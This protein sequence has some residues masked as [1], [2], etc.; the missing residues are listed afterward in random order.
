MQ[1]SYLIYRLLSAHQSVTH[2]DEIIEAERR[3]ELAPGLRC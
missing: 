1:L 3:A 2:H